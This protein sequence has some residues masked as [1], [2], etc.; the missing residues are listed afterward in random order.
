[1]DRDENSAL[2]ILERFLARQGP[3]TLPQRAVCL[4]NQKIKI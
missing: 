1:M 3:Y 2:N 4:G